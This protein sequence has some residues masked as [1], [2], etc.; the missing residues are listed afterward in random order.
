MTY[1]Q[2]KKGSDILKKLKYHQDN[3]YEI[4]RIITRIN[5]I[6]SDPTKIINIQLVEQYVSTPKISVVKQKLLDF[7]NDELVYTN[8]RISE[9]EEDFLSL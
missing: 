3:K 2:Y 9:L 4:E 1:D 6:T 7:I 8:K 5:K